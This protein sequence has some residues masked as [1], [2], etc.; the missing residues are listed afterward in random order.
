MC[1]VGYD[2]NDKK[3]MKPQLSHDPKINEEI[4]DDNE[5]YLYNV[6]RHPVHTE[7]DPNIVV[8]TRIKYDPNAVNKLTDTSNV[9]FDFESHDIDTVKLD[10]FVS[11]L[12]RDL[13][14]RGY[15]MLEVLDKTN[16]KKVKLLKRH[17]DIAAIVK[18]YCSSL[19]I[20]EDALK[21]QILNPGDLPPCALHAKM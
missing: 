17:L 11:N 5:T 4:T 16:T 9:E 1:Y 12:S 3:I 6:V 8:A 14:L 15:S 2:A 7:E 18:E 19:C 10:L 20:K 13:R 21:Q